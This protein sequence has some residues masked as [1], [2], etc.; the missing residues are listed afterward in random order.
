MSRIALREISSVP[1]LPAFRARPAAM[2]QAEPA[3]DVGASLMVLI[4]AIALFAGGHG[5]AHAAPAAAVTTSTTLSLGAAVDGGA[6]LASLGHA[7][8][9]RPPVTRRPQSGDN[10]PTRKF[11]KTPPRVLV[12]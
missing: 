5:G 2:H 7:T 1:A 11:R 4:A 12:G 8:T 10:T 3:F 9:G 6:R